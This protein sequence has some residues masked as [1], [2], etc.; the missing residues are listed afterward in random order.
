MKVFVA[1]A[2]G[3]IGSR[4]VPILVR[5]GYR[6]TGTTRLSAKAGCDVTDLVRILLRQMGNA[7]SANRNV[8]GF[9]GAD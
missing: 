4:L 3:V 8:T 7:K 9:H 6:V 1:E 2:T 5:A